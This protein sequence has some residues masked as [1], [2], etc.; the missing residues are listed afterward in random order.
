[1]KDHIDEVSVPEI[2]QTHKAREVGH[3]VH[4]SRENGVLLSEGEDVLWREGR[5]ETALHIVETAVDD[6]I[7]IGQTVDTRIHE[8]HVHEVTSLK[9]VCVGGSILPYELYN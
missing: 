5:L 6:L 3:P 2:V 7:S 4:I 1:M 8:I 9:R